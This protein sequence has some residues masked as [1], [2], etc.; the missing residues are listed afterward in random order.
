[1]NIKNVI[2]AILIS[3]QSMMVLANTDSQIS[4][5]HPV[6]P[7]LAGLEVNPVCKVRII[8]GSD[9]PQSLCRLTYS[10]KGTTDIKDIIHISVYGTDKK[11]LPDINKLIACSDISA[12][13]GSFSLDTKLEKDTSYFWLTVKT[14]DKVDLTHRINI[15]CKG[16]KTENGDLK[17]TSTDNK[18]GARIGVALRQAKQDGVNTSRIP[19]L[20]TA[21]DG[22]LLVLYD[23]RWES[24][25]DLQGDID[26]AM[27]RSKDGGQ[28]WL[29]MQIV[30]NM[31]EWGGLPEK[32][33]GV[34]DGSVL[35]NEKNGDIFVA[36]LWMHGVL[37]RITGKWIEGMTKDSTRWM[38]QWVGRG[39]QPGLGVKETSQFMIVKSVD[40]GKTW[41]KP[42]NI[43]S[44]TK[45]PEWWLYAPAPGHGITMNDGT[46]VFPT[47]GRD[48]N[49]KTFSNITYSKDGGKT[50]TASNPA[51]DD[52][53]E[54][55]V[56]QLSDGSLMLNMRDNRNG[57]NKETNG[58][59]VC[60][61]HD[62]GQT[63]KEHS[64]SHKVL[65]EPTCMASIHKHVYTEKGK[66]KH[67]LVFMNPNNYESRNH[68]TVKVSFDD[69]MSWPEKYWIELDEGSGFG[70]S[71]I[72]SIDEH[73]LGF[74]YEGSQSQLVFQQ[75]K[76][77]ELIK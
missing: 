7:V 22:T 72:T 38:H 37:D 27:N 49:G 23:A 44:A 47:Q 11:G 66:Q 53:T 58:R 56:V 54:C 1:M 64:T 55:M 39:S 36:G 30:L 3:I 62:L 43:T 8:K 67:I 45:H 28:S 65:T 18:N 77:E 32:Y 5:S 61:T 19:G 70:Y 73:T 35:V 60:V 63:W 16:A 50:W 75:L 29:P 31:K 34:S 21:K 41:S 68:F 26:I 10:T 15:N 13:K 9:E 17:M 14:K 24:S 40:N 42:V 52:V 4:C 57:G 2:G 48:K 25:R 74:V 46:L 76:L 6:L 33:N 59:R 12:S 71:C 69:G 20:A 51:Y